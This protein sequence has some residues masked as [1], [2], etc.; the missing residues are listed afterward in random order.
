MSLLQVSKNLFSPVLRN[1]ALLGLKSRDL[2]F[3]AIP[4]LGKAL[5]LLWT[6]G[7]LSWI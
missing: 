6:Q 7:N 4:S 5:P 2:L 3:I 1:K